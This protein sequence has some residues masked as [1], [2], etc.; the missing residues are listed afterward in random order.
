MDSLRRAM[1]EDDFYAAADDMNYYRSQVYPLLD[2]LKIPYEFVDRQPLRFGVGDSTATYRWE[3]VESPWFI[4]VYDGSSS[5]RVTH[6]ID[7]GIELARSVR[8][9]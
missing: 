1:G 5:P 2:S 3:E 9:N 7:Y 8:E 6:A 4:V